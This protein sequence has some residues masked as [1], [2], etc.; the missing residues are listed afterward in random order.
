MR[1]LITGRDGQ[2]G[3]ELHRLFRRRFETVATGRGELDLSDPDGIVATLRQLRPDLILNAAAYTAVDRAESEPDDA[4]AVNAHAPRILAEEAAGL[5]ACLVHYSTDY[6][7]DGTGDGPYAETDPPAPLGV[8]GRTKLLGE[9]ALSSAGVPHITLRVA[10]VYGRRPGNF[11]ST[12]LRLMSERR[13]VR[14][15]ADE[16][17]TPTWCRDIARA[18]LEIVDALAGAAGDRDG[19][20]RRLPGAMRDRGGLFHLAPEGH[21]SWHGFAESIL[22]AASECGI[23]PLTAERVTPISAREWP[24]DVRR[25]ANSRLSSEKLATTFGVRLPPWRDSV[26]TCVRE[27]AASREMIPI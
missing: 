2:V 9:R 23:A 24:S 10:W 11:L 3:G 13:E 14:V 1:V 22:E 21:T 19:V 5:G 4:L 8:Y 12:M 6:V 17:G 26:E 7:F 20:A 25:P 15:V 16:V 18:T 27:I